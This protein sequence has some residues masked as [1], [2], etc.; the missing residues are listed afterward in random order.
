MPL[1]LTTGGMSARGFGFTTQGY[2]NVT[3]TIASN[4][5]IYNI[6]AAATAAGWTGTNPLNLTLNVNSGVVVSGTGT[7]TSAAIV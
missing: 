4:A 2:Y 3:L 7:G 6:A 1:N 5:T